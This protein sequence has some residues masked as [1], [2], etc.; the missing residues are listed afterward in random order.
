MAHSENFSL[1]VIHSV[2]PV[3]NLFYF[4]VILAVEKCSGSTTL[5]TQQAYIYLQHGEAEHKPF[6]FALLHGCLMPPSMKWISTVEEQRSVMWQKITLSPSSNA[7]NNRKGINTIFMLKAT[8]HK[9]LWIEGNLSTDSKGPFCW[10]R[11]WS[12]FRW[13]QPYNMTNSALSLR[14]LRI[15]IFRDF[16]VPT[17]S[18]S[19][20]C[21]KTSTHFQKIS[22][23]IASS[24]RKF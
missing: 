4:C 13:K 18:E 7:K 23:I 2:M 6:H 11:Y 24:K 1:Y 14:A 12:D 3:V 22:F 15:L 9:G 20:I 19:S 8:I 17:I 16:K 5:K 21:F 10:R